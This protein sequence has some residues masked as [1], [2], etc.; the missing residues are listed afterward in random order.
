MISKDFSRL[1]VVAF[2]IAAPIAW[3]ALDTF[4]ERYPYR[5]SIPWWTFPLA[6][7]LAFSLAIGIVGMQAFRAAVDNPVKSLR[8]E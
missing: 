5:I 8:S 2:V 4:L 1:V 3:Y 7:G 6:G